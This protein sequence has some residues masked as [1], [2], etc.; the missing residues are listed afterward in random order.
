MPKLVKG[1]PGP[2]GA[3]TFSNLSLCPFLWWAE[4]GGGPKVAGSRNPG[5][6]EYGIGAHQVEAQHFARVKARQ[7]G[8]D[9]DE[10]ASPIGCLTQATAEG[11]VPY[12]PVEWHR[13][14]EHQYLRMHNPEQARGPKVVFLERVCELEFGTLD[15]PGHPNHGK[16]LRYAPRVDLCEWAK[17]YTLTDHK[18]TS[19]FGR[20]V[21]QGYSRS[22]QFLMMSLIGRVYYKS[23]FKGVNLHLIPKHD[24]THEHVIEKLPIKQALVD[25]MPDLFVELAH[26]R[27]RF[28]V[29]LAQGRDPMTL[30]RAI[31]KE[32]CDSRYGLCRQFD[33]CGGS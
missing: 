5:P 18:T 19:D 27:A 31:N 11:E 17:G 32:A 29:E 8:T 13:A 10:W 26:R 21:I 4:G 12:M 16:P 15:C 6:L 20:H 22:F 30:P 28:Q 9:P 33:L 24:E 14:I 23:E 2:D 3:T 7:E 25:R 1:G